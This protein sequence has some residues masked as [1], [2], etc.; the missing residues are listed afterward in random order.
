MKLDYFEPFFR[1]ASRRGLFIT[2]GLALAV[3]LTVLFGQ[4]VIETDGIVYIQQAQQV[5]LGHWD[6]AFDKT[7]FSL[8]P[9]L[10]AWTHTVV[11]RVMSVSFETAGL[12]LNL[13]FG[14]ALLYPLFMLARRY[15][16]A[17]PALLAGVYLAVL[18]PLVYVTCNVLRDASVLCLVCW[19]FYLCITAIQPPDI[20]D[21]QLG[22]LSVAGLLVFLA[23]LIRA[24]AL[25]V[26]ACM[27]FTLLWAH[28]K[29]HKHYGFHQRTYACGAMLMLILLC[30][31]PSLS[32]VRWRTGT[33]YVMK[34]DKIAKPYVL[35][36]RPTTVGGTEAASKNQIFRPDGTIDNNQVVHV[37]Q[38][39]RAKRY[40]AVLDAW[41]VIDAT[42]KSCHGVGLIAMG[43]A[44]WL[45]LRRRSIRLDDPLVP[46]LLSSAALYGAVCYRYASVSAY[47]SPRHVMIVT[48][49]AA[50]LVAVPFSYATLFK[51]WFRKAFACAAMVA[52]LVCAVESLKPDG[53]AYDTE[54]I[55]GK[56]LADILPANAVVAAPPTLL[57][58]VYYCQR[59]HINFYVTCTNPPPEC[60]SPQCYLLFN[61]RD[62]FQAVCYASLS[63]SLVRTD[64]TLPTEG[65][66]E[67]SLYQVVPPKKEDGAPIKKDQVVP[68]KKEDG[69]PVKKDQVVPPKKDQA[70]PSK[71]GQVP[72]PTTKK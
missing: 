46:Y 69:A 51:P 48:L 70:V 64:I 65:K 32:Y 67:F 11:S 71:K 1:A 57:R 50:V 24:E 49:P 61:L 7:D 6:K 16:G 8:Y 28:A 42:W 22:R 56:I 60:V 25:G 38:E 13:M 39:K 20:D 26:L 59:D 54:R 17:M 55:C 31:P 5:A 29:A 40:K 45:L 34:I 66:C 58:A 41:D 30:A 19:A 47:L 37:S 15:F 18:P 4:Q 53:Q 36:A 63:S 2:L 35:G 52:A 62:K 27:G 44:V 3:R 23:A 21:W 14:M 43:M 10:M 33:W 12:I 9:V 72:P 68:P